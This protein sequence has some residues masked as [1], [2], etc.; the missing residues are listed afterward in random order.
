[1]ATN[2]PE[3]P[4]WRFSEAKKQLYDDIVNKVVEG[5]HPAQIHTMRPIYTQYK[6]A[7]FVPNCTNLRE[8]IALFQTNAE[9]DSAALA[10]DIQLHPRP[11]LAHGGYPRWDGSE[12]ERFLKEDIDNGLHSQMPAQDLRE[13]RAAYMLFPKKVFSDHINQECRG[14]R[15]RPYWLARKALKDAEKA[16]AKKRR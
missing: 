2:P 8:Q 13:T 5:M 12:A 4:A 7:R 15:E 9:Q 16:K 11:T 10:R 14:R 1:M 6:L 3:P